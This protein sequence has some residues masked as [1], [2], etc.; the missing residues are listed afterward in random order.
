MKHY[1]IYIDNANTFTVTID[2]PINYADTVDC[3]GDCNGNVGFEYIGANGVPDPSWEQWF[4]MVLQ[5]VNYAQVHITSHSL[6]LVVAK[7]QLII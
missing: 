6:I 2:N 7:Q 3:Y 5:M 1:D 4:Q